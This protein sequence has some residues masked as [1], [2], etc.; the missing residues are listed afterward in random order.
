[1]PGTRRESN[2]S[3][4]DGLSQLFI[5]Q[6]GGMQISRR[7]LLRAAAATALAALFGGCGD[8]AVRSS[9]SDRNSS[10][11]DS[12]VTGVGALPA[13]ALPPDALPADP[14]RTK[15]GM[16]GDSITKA[17]SRALTAVLEQRG[18]SEIDIEAKV[19]R[20]IAVG[21]GKSEPLSGVKTLYTMIAEGLV[22]DVWVIAMGTNDV[23]KYDGADAYAPLIDQ[24]MM[25][26][27]AEVPILWVD[28]YNP[29][30]LAATKEFNLVLR[31]RA[32]ARG[33]TT[34]V[35]WFDLASDPKSKIL[36]SDRIHPNDKGALVFADLV[37][38][39]LA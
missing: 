18:F 11:G 23:G 17:S 3:T 26:P 20:R 5:G 6:N 22:P 21:D 33:N 31:E 27:D 4:T 15:L 28:V 37:A 2:G 9:A 7:T 38:G 24:M 29:A 34:V 10:S 13:G 16:V 25:L 32:K 39:A 19:N 35:S 30:Q 14:S 36:R 1:M 8:G 12:S